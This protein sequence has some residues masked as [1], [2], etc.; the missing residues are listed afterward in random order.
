MQYIPNVQG[1]KELAVPILV[2]KTTVYV[3]QNIREIQVDGGWATYQWDEYQYD[4]DEYITLMAN[5]NSKLQADIDYI[6][7]MT[8]VDTNV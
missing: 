6:S 8:G 7:I 2:Q 4:K 1:S 5:Q 3:K